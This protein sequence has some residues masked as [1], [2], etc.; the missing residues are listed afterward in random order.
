MAGI[1]R[2]FSPLIEAEKFLPQGQTSLS[3]STFPSAKRLGKQ[4]YT[5]NALKPDCGKTW[6]SCCILHHGTCSAVEGQ[7]PQP[8]VAAGCGGGSTA[9][10]QPCCALCWGCCPKAAVQR[11]AR[12][13]PSHGTSSKHTPAARWV[14]C[15]GVGQTASP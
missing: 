12:A 3:S 13:L 7:H 4:A 8:A 11:A 1:R 15:F 10:P 5:K 9:V 14:W 6:T 2:G